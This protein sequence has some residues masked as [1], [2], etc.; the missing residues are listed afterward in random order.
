MN[1]YYFLYNAEPLT[2]EK[3]RDAYLREGFTVF[4]EDEKTL[5]VKKSEPG[6]EEGEEKLLTLIL[7][8]F[9][10]SFFK[11]PVTLDL[12]PIMN[13]HLDRLIENDFAS[14]KFHDP[15]LDDLKILQTR[16]RINASSGRSW[17]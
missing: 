6:K 13:R 9:R 17:S 16:A 15:F 12:S 7:Q 14:L 8:R 1:E 3:T 2:K 4:F 11:T 5:I 10:R